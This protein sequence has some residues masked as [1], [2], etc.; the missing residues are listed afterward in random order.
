MGKQGVF[1]VPAG[2]WLFAPASK[3]KHAFLYAQ[4]VYVDDYSVVTLLLIC[5]H[6]HFKTKSFEITAL[7]RY[8]RVY[9]NKCTVFTTGEAHSRNLGM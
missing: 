7:E 2:L 5:M 1:V 3:Y 4:H 6:R 8:R 9:M